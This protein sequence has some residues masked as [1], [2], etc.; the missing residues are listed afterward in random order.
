[1]STTRPAGV[2]TAL[3][4]VPRMRSIR[5]RLPFVAAVAPLLSLLACVRSAAQIPRH[6]DLRHVATRSGDVAWVSS[7]QNQG[8]AEDCWSFASATAM[9]S[10]LLMQG[11][12]PT[13]HV[14]PSPAVSSWHLSTANGNPNQLDPA[15]AFS[16]RSSV[17]KGTN[18][19]GFEY[20]A[21]GYV[22]RGSGEWTI[23]SSYTLAAWSPNVT[24]FGGGPVLVQGDENAFPSGISTYEGPIADF[25]PSPLTTL[26]PVVD[27]PTAWRV[28][29]VSILDQGFS[30]NVHLPTVSGSVA[31]GGQQYFT[32]RFDQGANDPQVRAVKGAI[33]A[34]GAVTTYMNAQYDAF[35]A[36]G[37]SGTT[38]TVDYVNP[39]AAP[40]N[41]DHSVTII[42]WDDDRAITSVNGATTGAWLVQNS[43]GTD[44]MGDVAGTTD[45]TFWASYDDA[46]IGR[47]GV[48][49]YR[50][51][52]M[53]G[54]S[55]NVLQNELGPMA[56]AANFEVIAGAAYDQVGWIGSPTGMGTVD[57]STVM[58]ILNPGSTEVLAGL[59]L[60]TQV[61]GVDVLASIYDWN[62]TTRSFGSLLRQATFSSDSIGF[63]LGDLPA[64]TLLGERSYA[65][66]LAYSQNGSPLTRA[67]GVTIGFSGINGFADAASNV[68]DPGLSYYYDTGAG[69]WV[70]MNTI[71]H[72]SMSG[73]NAHGGVLFLKG[74]LSSVP[75]IDPAGLAGG[76]SA[77]L[78]ALALVEHRLV[79]LRRGRHAR[80]A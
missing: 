48:A 68:V 25:S 32:Y 33:L 64:T 45:G 61:A 74:Y 7:I 24:T 26:L 39:Y 56:Y 41:S 70:D 5:P 76:L 15:Q 53:A 30:N 51:E 11:L 27:Q 37:T 40:G 80:A 79:R 23:P 8:V 36:S 2:P 78:A 50:L 3:T 44:G 42:G 38:V 29:N 28:T 19:G 58:S 73:P 12:I 55:Q 22:T 52:S 75:E 4:P 65:V 1:M 46:V 63:F 16:G 20:Q 62:A 71:R 6:Y 49:S 57:A 18:W 47:S 60:S 43:W 31:I 69:E 72:V 54:W 21:L 17:T 14:A 9:N 13:A 66:V 77:A 34:H 35:T 59:G 67:A 10:N